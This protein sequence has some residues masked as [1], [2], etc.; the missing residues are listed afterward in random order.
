MHGEIRNINGNIIDM[1]QNKA[2]E[3]FQKLKRQKVGEFSLK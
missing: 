2:E 1:W 3:F